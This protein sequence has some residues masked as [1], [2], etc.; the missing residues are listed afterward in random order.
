M[1]L[2]RSKPSIYYSIWN[3]LLLSQ[4]N[5]GINNDVQDPFWFWFMS[6]VLKNHLMAVKSG[7]SSD[8]NQ[9]FRSTYTHGAE[10]LFEI[11]CF[12]VD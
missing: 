6:V 7:K 2:F 9:L 4:A 11:A 12:L 10:L 5:C 1:P 8:I 3:I